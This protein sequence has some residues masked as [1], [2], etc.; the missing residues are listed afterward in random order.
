MKPNMVSKLEKNSQ[1]HFVLPTIV[2]VLM[3][4]KPTKLNEIPEASYN[5]RINIV[6]AKVMIFSKYE[7][8]QIDT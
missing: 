4:R 2:F 1:T 6:K 3:L 7:S 8:R 5:K